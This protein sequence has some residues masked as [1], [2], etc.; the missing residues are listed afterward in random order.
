MK[1][2]TI[3]TES[4]APYGKVIEF[5]EDMDERFHIIYTEPEA[6]WRIAVLRVQ[7]HRIDEME[8]HPTTAESFEPVTGITVLLLAAPDN[9]E[10]QAA[11]LLDRPVCLYP[12]TW[13]QVM[14][15]SDRAV[16]KITENLEVP[17]TQFYHLPVPLTAGLCPEE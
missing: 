11:F 5:P 10:N 4:F 13:H 8:L 2:K 3:N 6:P 12:G 15:L 17:D 14:A 1:L 9:P 16:V 7:E